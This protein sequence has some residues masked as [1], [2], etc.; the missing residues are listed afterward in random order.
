MN[1][2]LCIGIDP[3]Y[4]SSPTGIALVSNGKL[5]DSF[6]R[7]LAGE[8]PGQRIR[9][10]RDL[11]ESLIRDVRKGVY[12]PDRI[13][14]LVWEEPH[15]KMMR[16]GKK[17]IPFISAFRAL[18]YLEAVLYLV[19]EDLLIPYIP[20]NNMTIKKAL[21]DSG[22]VKK[23]GMTAAAERLSNKTFESQD[24]ADAALCAFY[25]ERIFE[26]RAAHE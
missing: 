3:G 5:L 2:Y 24:E 13:G 6:S 19:C 23:S 8:Y 4:K 18:S 26:N 10:F 17:T 14:L 22:G 1:K 25:A 12:G 7:H 20:V 11:V 9:A 16:K 21:C 15:L